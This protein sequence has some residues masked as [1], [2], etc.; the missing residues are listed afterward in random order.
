VITGQLRESSAF[1]SM[2]TLLSLGYVVLGHDGLGRALRF[3]QGAV[4]AFLGVD[5]QEVRAFVKTVHRADF[6]AVG[7]FALDAV[8]Q[9]DIG[10]GV[11]R[12]G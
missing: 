8:V 3:A 1:S 4:D 10:H 9:D 6:D 5:H 11:L 2:K 12:F 7:V